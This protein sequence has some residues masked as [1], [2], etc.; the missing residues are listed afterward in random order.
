MPEVQVTE[1]VIDDIPQLGSIAYSVARTHYQ[2]TEKEF[3]EPTP[4]D[5]TEYI[6]KCISDDGI[7]TL[8]A[9]MGDEVVGYVVVYFNTFP[10]K[11]FQFSKRA[12]I[13]S[14]GVAE[15]HRRQGVGKALLKAVEN[16]VKK[17]N[18][19]II[20]IDYYTFNVAA[21]N[22]YKSLGYQENKR[23]MRKFI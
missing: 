4:A 14:I 6:R 16:E 11:Y 19:S 10:D 20:E 8:K 12:F 3:K 1:A 2:K 17:H 13:G 23:Y 5:Q 21:E 9:Q 15:N 7:L 18:I 22:L